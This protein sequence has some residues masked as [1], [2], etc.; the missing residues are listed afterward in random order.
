M[1]LTHKLA[2]LAECQA[3]ILAIAIAD[4]ERIAAQSMGLAFFKR[5]AS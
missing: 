5:Q 2:L 3:L 4:L 1:D